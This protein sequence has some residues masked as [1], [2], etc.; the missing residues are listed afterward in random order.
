MAQ[1]IVFLFSLLMCSQV[2]A[3]PPSRSYVY[4]SGT[5]ILASEVTANEDAI[6]NYLQSGVDNIADGTIVNA[7]I[8]ASANIAAT[9]INLTSVAQNITNTG[10]ITNTGAVT[11]TGDVGV[12]GSLVVG[13]GGTID[14]I[15]AVPIGGIIMWSGSVASIPTG[16]E[17][18]DGT[19]AI[20]CPDLG[21]RFIIATNGT[22][23]VGATGDGSI[24]AH[25]HATKGSD[26]TGA[27]SDGFR[28]K[29]ADSLVATVATTSYGTG[30]EVIAKYYSLAYIIRVQ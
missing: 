28:Y 10:T 29:G 23:A 4:T 15:G 13:G 20:T 26:T 25:T 7:D 19:C 14:G 2:L 18:S 24:P 9:K 30:T 17:L 5:A 27:T 11:I 8:N 1:F 16:W 6:F 21:G 3:A 12:T 22:Y